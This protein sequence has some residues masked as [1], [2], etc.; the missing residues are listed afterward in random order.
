M[1]TVDVF[2]AFFE[3]LTLRGPKSVSPITGQS[4]VSWNYLKLVQAA[5]AF[6][7]DAR[8]SRSALDRERFPQMGAFRSGLERAC[9][10]DSHGSSLSS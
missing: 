7:R 3:A 8:G 9:V 6:W 10:H 2:F 4:M 5:V 1:V